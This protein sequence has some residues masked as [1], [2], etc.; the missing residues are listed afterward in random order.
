VLNGI[1]SD[2]DSA[3]VTAV[4]VDSIFD[5]AHLYTR[6]IYAE[7]EDCEF[8][9]TLDPLTSSSYGIKD[10][11]STTT[12]HVRCTKSLNMGVD[13]VY[14]SSS[15]SVSYG[16]AGSSSTYGNNSFYVTDTIALPY[17]KY[18]HNL[19]TTTVKAEKNWWGRSSPNAARFAGPVDYTPT[20]TRA[21]ICNEEVAKLAVVTENRPTGY[22][23]GQNTPNPFNPSTTIVFELQARQDVRIEIFNTL[24]QRVKAFDLGNQPAGQHQIT[25]DGRSQQGQSMGSG[26]YCYRISMPDFVATKR[27]LLLK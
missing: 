12:G 20:L 1:G 22:S 21:P 16:D 5:G 4:T 27:M 10:M 18:F 8:R 2:Y 17:T 19:G 11:G 3:F 14:R 26:V 24:G 9:S 6:A 7:I 23:L 25:W 13:C 15:S